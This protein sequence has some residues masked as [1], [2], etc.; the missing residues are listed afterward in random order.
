MLQGPGVAAQ[1]HSS[2]TKMERTK[3][4]FVKEEDT[5]K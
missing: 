1:G 3:I 2:R 4:N 5:I